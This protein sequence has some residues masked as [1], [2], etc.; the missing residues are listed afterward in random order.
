M[1]SEEHVLDLDNP[2]KLLRVLELMLDQAYLGIVFVDPDGIIRFMNRQYEELI[3]VD[4]KETYGKHITEYFPDSRLPVVLRTREPELGWKYQYA[5]R[6][7]LVVNRIPIMRG[8][9]LSV[10]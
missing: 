8:A 6:G 4:R 3:G 1:T 7:T 2:E 9:S 10:P 5:G